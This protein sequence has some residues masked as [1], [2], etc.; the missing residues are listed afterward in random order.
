V[1]LP[2]QGSAEKAERL[3]GGMASNEYRVRSMPNLA[4]R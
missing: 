3:S 4:L 2:K 1:V